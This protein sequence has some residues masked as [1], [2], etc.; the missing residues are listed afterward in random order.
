MKMV[1][2]KLPKR[3]EE[4]LKGMTVPVEVERDLWPYG[5]RLTFEPEQVDK[6]LNLEKITVGQKVSVE[7]IGEVTSIRINEEKEGKKKYS[8]E[9]QLHEVGC[10]SKGRMASETMG[11]AISR[12]MEAHKT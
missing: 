12:S 7:G 1:N 9:I 6:L 4:E 10:E 2:I 5:L 8:V 3:T 11:E